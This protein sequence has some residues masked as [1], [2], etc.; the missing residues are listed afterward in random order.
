MS[1]CHTL[2]CFKLVNDT[3][4]CLSSLWVLPVPCCVL[5]QLR[6]PVL[7]SLDCEWLPL[8][9]LA[10]FQACW[11][12]LPLSLQSVSDCYT[13]LHF[14]F[15]N[16]NCSCISSLWVVAVPCCVSSLLT[17][18]ALGSLESEWLPCF[19]VFQVCL[20]HPYCFSLWGAAIYCCVSSLLMMPVLVS[21]VCGWQLYLA[22]FQ[23]NWQCL[24]LA[25]QYVSGWCVFS[26]YW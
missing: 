24:S 8:P 18:T 20:W 7:I 14:K 19:A 12:H 17:M 21:P 9:S 16:D 11:W 1:G 10:V 25:F 2:L 13:L 22:V 4:S 26:A 3:S 23:A 5:D 6:I 15:T